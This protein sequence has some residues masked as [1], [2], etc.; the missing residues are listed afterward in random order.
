MNHIFSFLFVIALCVGLINAAINKQKNSVHFRNDLGPNNT[1]W[2][3]CI[4]DEDDFGDH[5]LTLGET[6]DFSFYDS[7]VGTLIKCDLGKGIRFRFHAKFIAYEGVWLIPHYGQ[8]NFWYAKEDGI[9]FAHGKDIPKLKYTWI[10][11]VFISG[12]N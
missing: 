10:Y 9:Y 5:F 6:Y 12:H 4:S 11:K 8:M 2:I 7:V 3:H 1:L